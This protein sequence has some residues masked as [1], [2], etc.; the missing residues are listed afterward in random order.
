MTSHG[1]LLLLDRLNIAVKTEH[2]SKQY[3]NMLAVNDVNIQVHE[4][5]T[6]ALLGPN[7]AGKTTLL[8]MLEGITAPTAGS[9]SVFGLNYQQNADQIRNSIGVSLQETQFYD[10]QTVSETVRLFMS[11]YKLPIEQLEHTLERF[12]L[13][14]IKDKFVMHL[15]G[16][17]KQR[18]SLAI[19]MVHRPRILFLDEPTTGL[20]PAA[21]ASLWKLIRE[22]ISEGVTLLLT[23]HY[24]E[25]AEELCDRV[26]LLNNGKILSDG[27]IPELMTK[28]P[29]TECVRFSYSSSIERRLLEQVPGV[30]GIEINHDSNLVTLDVDDAKRVVSYFINEDHFYNLKDFSIAK[31]TLND[32]FLSLTGT[33][34]DG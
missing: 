13:A 3:G 16:G 21:R 33:N 28:L 11:F 24:M 17:Q 32:V 34:L 10:R 23:T 31:R 29:G 6:I 14:I 19:A 4:G 22:L 7:G 1:L 20:D 12:N 2:L 25:E 8:E 26:L 15:S 5:E 30:K 18:L 9:L 27:T